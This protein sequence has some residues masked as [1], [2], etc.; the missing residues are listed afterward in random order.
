MRPF[1]SDGEERSLGAVLNLLLPELFPSARS[2]SE[3]VPLVHGVP[4]DLWAPIIE[5]YKTTMCVDGFLHITFNAHCLIMN[6]MVAAVRDYNAAI[7]ALNRLQTN[8]AV[9]EQ[10]KDKVSPHEM[11]T[12][13]LR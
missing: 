4:I 1:E 6:R 5:L 13:F 7:E 10:I 9:I 3:L 2:C 8:F 11:K 12:L